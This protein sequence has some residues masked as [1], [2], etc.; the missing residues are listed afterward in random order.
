L[1]LT[2]TNTIVEI[3]YDPTNG[4]ITNPLFTGDPAAAP[5]VDIGGFYSS[6]DQHAHCILAMPTGGI[7]EIFY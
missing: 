5:M 4:I 6:D 7:K 1:I 2:P 3:R